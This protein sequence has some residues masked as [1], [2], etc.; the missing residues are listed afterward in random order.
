MMDDVP[1]V[2]F[3]KSSNPYAPLVAIAKR[4]GVQPT[5]F[6]KPD[7]ITIMPF[8]GGEAYDLWEIVNAIIDRIDRANGDEQVTTATSG[9]GEGS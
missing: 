2:T 3:V 9:Q 7:T 8:D 6:A 1:R 5:E 4:L